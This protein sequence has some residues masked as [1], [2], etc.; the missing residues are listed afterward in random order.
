MLG[1]FVKMDELVLIAEAGSWR[2]TRWSD[3]RDLPTASTGS[4]ALA[5]GAQTVETT[6]SVNALLGAAACCVLK[7][8]LLYRY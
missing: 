5:P 1:L 7:L 4:I 3:A 6:T 8:C 2:S